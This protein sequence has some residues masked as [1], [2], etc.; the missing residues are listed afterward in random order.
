MGALPSK[1]GH[2]NKASL[3]DGVLRLHLLLVG[4]LRSA[5]GRDIG[6]G[7]TPTKRTRP[8]LRNPN[9]GRGEKERRSSEA[10]EPLVAT[11]AEESEGM[12]GTIRDAHALLEGALGSAPPEELKALL[13][14]VFLGKGLYLYAR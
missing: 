7:H 10:C 3:A 11:G 2:S 1:E 9:T 14:W 5:G 6:R 4:E 12:A 13:E 8:G